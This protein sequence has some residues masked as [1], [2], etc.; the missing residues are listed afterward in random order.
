MSLP[1]M[2]RSAGSSAPASCANVGSRSI[3]VVTS[4]LL[5]P[6][7][8]V[9]GAEHADDVGWAL[10]RNL[11]RNAERPARL[12]RTAAGCPERLHEREAERSR[13]GQEF[14]E[15]VLGEDHLVGTCSSS[16]LEETVPFALDGPS[17]PPAGSRC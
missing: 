6:A 8:D 1:S 7:V 12:V 13:A 10:L 9:E 11:V 5:L 16:Q 3:I 2:T 15:L 14:R 4:S 17:G